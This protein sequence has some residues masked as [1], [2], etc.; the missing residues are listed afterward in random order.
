GLGE[1][2]L[3]GRPRGAGMATAAEPPR[4]LGGIDAGA[5]AQADPGPRTLLREQ[6]GDVR[7]LALREEVDDPLR[8]AR[9]GPGATQVGLAEGRMDE[10]IPVVLEARQDDPE[11]LQLGVRL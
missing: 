10:P 1:W 3:D 8:L 4:Q 11:E 7:G 2:Q 6:Q 9:L 5:R